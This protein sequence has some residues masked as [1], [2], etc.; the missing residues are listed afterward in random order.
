VI[1]LRL[2]LVEGARRSTLSRR[3]PPFEMLISVTSDPE[4]RQALFRDGKAAGGKRGEV[5]RS[6]QFCPDSLVFLLL[7]TPAFLSIS[8]GFDYCNRQDSR[9]D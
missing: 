6:A 1:T 9:K 5:L 8:I 2:I 3:A 7:G 4:L